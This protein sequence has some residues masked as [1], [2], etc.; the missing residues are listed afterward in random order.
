MSLEELQRSFDR[1]GRIDPFWAILSHPDKR[2]NKWRA[3][4]FFD[5]G[6][7]EIKD[8][9]EHV[10]SLGVRISRRKALDFGCGVGRLTQALAR[11]FG[12][13]HG[14]DI[15]PSMIELAN[16]YNRYGDRCKY[17]LNNSDSLQLFADDSFDLI[18]S[19]I[20]LQH[21]R[22]QYSKGYIREFVRVLAPSGLLLFQLPSGRVNANRIKERVTK[23]MP[24]LLRIYRRIRF[25]YGSLI[26]MHGIDRQEVITI[27]ERSGARIIEV[28]EEKGSGWISC[29]YCATKL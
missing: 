20:T 8:L 14:V 17:H 27:L 1:L 24:T 15:A 6:E 12:E 11:Y 4:E 19:Y 29:R 22:P 21:I 9:M 13:V 16:R 10:E 28:S 23:A 3:G 2:G 18:Y 25:G 5:T 7:R 26:S